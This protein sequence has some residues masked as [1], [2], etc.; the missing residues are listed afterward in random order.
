MPNRMTTCAALA[1]LACLGAG[2]STTRTAGPEQAVSLPA[3]D[4]AAAAEVAYQPP[5]YESVSRE[6]AVEYQAAQAAVPLAPGAPERYTVRRGDTLWDIS[7]MF[8][9]DPWLWPE[10]WYVNPQIDNPHL[11]Y[12]GDVLRLVWVD[13]RPR[14][15][16]ERD[17]VQANRVRVS[18]QIRYES[19]DEAITAIPYDAIASFLSKPTVLDKKTARRSPYIVDIRESHLVAGANFHVYVR[20]TDAP[21]GTRF[22][23]YHIGVPLH[24]PDNGKLLG[25]EGLYVG[26]GRLT[27]AGDPATMFL[28]ETRREALI[29]DRLILDEPSVPLTFF[30]SAPSQQV[31]GRI[32]HVVDGVSLIGSYQI[33]SLNVGT[34]DGVKPG[35]VLSVYSTGDVVRDR[36]ASTGLVGGLFN[37]KVR[38]PDEY[39]GELMVFQVHENMSFGL[40]MQA[41]N[42][43]HVLDTVRNPR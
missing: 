25:Y 43:I 14:I 7:K 29:G 5:V 13:G 30:P 41:T 4:T 33:V 3:T 35:H 15:M 42:E 21:A 1:T 8:L 2:C 16:L 27:D 18:P 20:G 40:I 31:E 38:L 11:I 12:P 17:V 26:E 28:T 32:M 6:D 37:R 39:S 23:I 36:F 10:I 24:D 9:D 19:L 34:E 22:R